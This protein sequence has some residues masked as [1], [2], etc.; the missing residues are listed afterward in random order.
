MVTAAEVDEVFQ[1]TG[2]D[3]S[4]IAFPSLREP[5]CRRG[6][7]LYEMVQFAL[8]RGY[9]VTP[10]AQRYPHVAEEGA[11]EL[12]LVTP[13]PVIDRLYELFDMVA[14][15]TIPGRGGHAIAWSVEGQVFLDP[16]GT[17]YR[18]E[19]NQLLVEILLLCSPL[20]MPLALFGP[21]VNG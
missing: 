18:R 14:V 20:K 16:N 13:G 7:T 8:Y 1:Y 2:H 9:T 5:Y 10:M 12:T 4:A 3:G 21:H 11:G 17:Q 15:G 19:Q 6:F